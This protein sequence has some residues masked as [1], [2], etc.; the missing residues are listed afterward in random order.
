MSFEVDKVSESAKIKIE[1]AGGNV[2]V[3]ES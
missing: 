2:N 1:K 3:K